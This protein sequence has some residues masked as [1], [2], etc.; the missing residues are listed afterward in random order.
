MDAES[1]KLLAHLLQTSRIASLGTSHDGAPFV[2]MVSVARAD[3]GSAFYIHVS[4]LAQHTRDMEADPRVSLLL[5]QADDGRADPQTLVRVT[6]QCR[7]EKIERTDESYKSIQIL[8]V[9]QFP[10]SAQMFSFG[11]FN[12]WKLVPEK[13]RFVAGF[14]KAFNL[15]PNDLK[16]AITG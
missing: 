9:T 15:V 14:A 8:Y 6:I 13:V 1:E 7:A 12:L 2:S 5:A 10:A 11:D 16:R 4:R 3:D